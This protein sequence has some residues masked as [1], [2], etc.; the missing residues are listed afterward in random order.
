M[1][2]LGAESERYHAEIASLLDDLGIEVVVAVGDEARG[3]LAGAEEGITVPDAASFEAIAAV[4]RP[5]DAILV[6]G[7]R[8]VGLEGIP[9]LI[10]KHSLT[11]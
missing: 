6:K 3:Y 7:S 2:E 11:W 9:M 4:L 1:A 8:A 10:Q 5:G